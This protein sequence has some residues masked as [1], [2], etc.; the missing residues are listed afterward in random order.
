MISQADTD[1]Q[2][3]AAHHKFSQEL[4]DIVRDFRYDIDAFLFFLLLDLFFWITWLWL[5]KAYIK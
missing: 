1:D 5:P 4:F 3:F 2:A